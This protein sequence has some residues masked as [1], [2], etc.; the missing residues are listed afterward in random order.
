M[1]LVMMALMFFLADIEDKH[2]KARPRVAAP[3]PAAVEVEA[4]RPTEFA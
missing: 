3:A 2:L 1:P 4:P